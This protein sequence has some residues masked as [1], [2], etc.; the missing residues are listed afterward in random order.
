LQKIIDKYKIDAIIDTKEDLNSNLSRIEKIGESHSN[1]DFVWELKSLKKHSIIQNHLS[2]D[3]AKDQIQELIDN[4]YTFEDGIITFDEYIPIE[5]VSLDCNK[6][7]LVDPELF[8]KHGYGITKF[9][10]YFDFRIY[11]IYC[12]G[13][14]PNLN[15]VNNRFCLDGSIT[16]K[17]VTLYNLEQ[18]VKP[19][20][21]SISLDFS[22]LSFK[23]RTQIRKLVYECN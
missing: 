3:K 19:M 10:I 17:S 15:S 21:G 5:M 2:T 6:V 13:K 18:F 9:R 22:Y 7:F 20:L 1:M 11:D 8:K 16:L 4:G 23:E 14:H 12:N